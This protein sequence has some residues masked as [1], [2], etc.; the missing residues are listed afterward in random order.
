MKMG[1][2][3]MI[4]SPYVSWR[5]VYLDRY[6]YLVCANGYG[7]EAVKEARMILS[8]QGMTL[9]FLG[10]RTGWIRGAAGG[11]VEADVLISQVIDEHRERPLPSGLLLA[12]G[13]TCGQHLLADPRV[14]LL[15]QQMLTAGHP[16]GLLRPVSYALVDLLER[17]ARGSLLLWQEA[18]TTAEFIPAFVNRIDGSDEKAR[19]SRCLAAGT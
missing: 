17:R 18:Q 12:G 3:I 8:G 14:H 11:R 5:K 4:R 6:Y 16:V 1:E 15:V 13:V 2:R 10:L 19:H 7:E 9:A